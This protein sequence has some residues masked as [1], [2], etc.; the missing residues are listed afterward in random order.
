MSPRRLAAAFAIVLGLVVP[1]AAQD[2][3]KDKDKNK[4]GGAE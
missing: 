4:D 3:D 2:K 1:L